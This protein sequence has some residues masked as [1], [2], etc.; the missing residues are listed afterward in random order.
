MTSV[1][2]FNPAFRPP[3]GRTAQRFIH[4]VGSSVFVDDRPADD[5]WPQHFLGLIEPSDSSDVVACWGVDVPHGDDPSY[6]AAL[7]LY[8]YF[9]RATEVD[10]LVAGRAVQLV[11]WAR[12]HR[13]CGRCGTATE[14]QAGERD[15]KS[16][17]LNSSHT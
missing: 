5:A 7:D 2:T 12:T 8:S 11:D 1:T 13:F 4:V 17:R 10:W 16:T 9:G 6:G 15:R 14:P 3:A